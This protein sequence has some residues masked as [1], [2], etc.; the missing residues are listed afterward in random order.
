MD[1][2]ENERRSEAAG[3]W[4]RHIQWHLRRDKRLQALPK[5]PRNGPDDWKTVRAALCWFED[6][7][8]V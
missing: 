1:P 6:A 5:L 3:A 2:A 8:Q 4:W 7:A